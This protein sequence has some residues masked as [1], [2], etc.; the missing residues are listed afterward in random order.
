MELIDLNRTLLVCDVENL[1]RKPVL[2]EEDFRACRALIHG[3]GLVRPGDHVVLATNPGSGI[4]ARTWPGVR[5]VTRHGPSGA[6]RAL[7]E[8]LQGEAIAQ[9]FRRVVVGSGD[10]IF[11]D[12]VI[13][14]AQAG[15]EVVVVA[16]PEAL[17]KRL[18]IA[19]H[20]YYPW[21][22]PTRPTSPTDPHAIPLQEAA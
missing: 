9:R 11:T 5:L 13:R 15:L 3:L 18:R 21:P 14:L 20:R 19:A 4:H 16:P 17:S 22:S 12:P 7:V 2:G 6:D 8:V 1:M 10:G